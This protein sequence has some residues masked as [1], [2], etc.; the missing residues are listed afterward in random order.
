MNIM[1]L[2]ISARCEVGG[3]LAPLNEGCS[4]VWQRH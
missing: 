3:T 2:Y 4:S 1:P